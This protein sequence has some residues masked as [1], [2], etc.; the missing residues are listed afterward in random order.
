MTKSIKFKVVSCGIDCFG[1][2]YTLNGFT[3]VQTLKVDDSIKF[4]CCFKNGSYNPKI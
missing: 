4:N 2:Y 1:S 3:S